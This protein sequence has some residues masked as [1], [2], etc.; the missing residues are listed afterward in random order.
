MSEVENNIN[1]IFNNSG[2]DRKIVVWY[3]DDGDFEDDITSIN[4]ENAELHLLTNDNSIFTKFFIEHE[5][6][7][8]NFLVYAPFPRPSDENNYIADMVHYA[9]SFS[10]DPIEEICKEL[11]IPFDLKPVVSKF[12]KFFNAKSR[13]EKFNNLNIENFTEN[14]IIKGILASLTSQKTLELDNIL[15]E[16][17]INENI[18]EYIN[19]FN[20]YEI[21]D[22]FWNLMA[23][24]YGFKMDN[25]SLIN[26]SIF[27]L[28]NYTEDSFNGKIPK[29]WNEYVIENNNNASVFVEKFISNSNYYDRYSEISEGVANK[30]NLKNSIKN[31]LVDSY[32]E[33]DTFRL[34][35]EKIINY[36]I[37]LLYD[38]HD[39]FDYSIL[40]ERA[41][42]HFYN[43]FK[44][45]YSIIY[46]AN[47]FL[48]L[49]NEFKK[50][51]IYDNIDDIIK[52]FTDK[53]AFIDKSYRKFY[54]FYDKITNIDDFEN[55]NNL[56]QLIENIYI[57]FLDKINPA[58]TSELAKLDSLSDLKIKKQWKF[59]NILHNINQKTA[60]IISDAF[61]YGCAV[62]L[63]DELNK[64]PTRTTSIQ[65]MISTI[66][67]YTSLGM[68]ALLPHRELKY[69]GSK[70]L[71]DGNEARSL[72]QRNRQLK[73][74]YKNAIAC[75]YDDIKSLTSKEMKEI[76]N[77]YELIYLYHDQ[78]DARGDHSAT[79]N[80]VFN[81]AQEAIDEIINMIKKLRN[82][83]NISK[84]Y[85]TADHGFIYKKNKLEE[86][87][88][89]NLD[90]IPTIIKNRRFI[91]TDEPTDIDG[92][93]C[94]S[95]DYI[96]NPNLY[97][98]TPK[99]V[100]L[101][102]APGSGLN[103]VHGGASLEECIIPL[104]EVKAKKGAKHQ[105]TVNLKL[106]SNRNKI[107]NYDTMLTFYQDENVSNKVLPL[108]ADI[109]FVDEDNNVISN[110][111]PIVADVN[112]EYAE[113]REFKERFRLQ[114]TKYSKDNKYYLVIKDAK[115]G[116]IL[117]RIEF[118]IDIAFQV[119]SFF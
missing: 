119:D 75:K 59:S 7:N 15:L 12:K 106:I 43:E 70:I 111:V 48:G 117:D 77:G 64:D 112:S 91:L 97:V 85:I 41:R 47:S 114:K 20:K 46:W 88:K 73:S 116:V 9:S 67:S 104:V 19:E 53:W 95:L 101:F 52:G 35:D 110:I 113:D 42:K 55:L 22:E 105:N 16:I 66:P 81:A 4:L 65:P 71:V 99:G 36:Y 98:T 3:D 49:I 18:K 40:E 79:E 38:T 109:Y 107:T 17:L 69:E 93:I 23:I 29:L 21:L 11:G 27:L 24:N 58:F 84:F 80:E 8:R 68:S 89:V 115:D 50:D 34:F 61:R 100:D 14:N 1:K 92:T 94:L 103:Y 44:N 102:K 63:V 78:I 10:A 37:N 86:Y 54:Y 57:E 90:N 87:D 32:V 72:E 76:L 60:V 45:H 39:S 25:P 26:L 82:S 108:D 74:Y 2:E 5:N 13:R 6:P 28:L 56:T 33:C 83:I 31:H 118:E 51:F 30:I 62:E 96:N